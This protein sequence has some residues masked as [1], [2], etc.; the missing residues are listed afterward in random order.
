MACCTLK[1]VTM[2]CPFITV[3]VGYIIARASSLSEDSFCSSS[4]NCSGE[5]KGLSSETGIYETCMAS[6]LFNGHF[7]NSFSQCGCGDVENEWWLWKIMLVCLLES[8]PIFKTFLYFRFFK[9]DSWKW[10]LVFR[11]FWGAVN[12]EWRDGGWVWWGLNQLMVKED[13]FH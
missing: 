3:R 11:C 2:V 4:R 10:N 1:A 5:K 9:F 13:M 8:T 7:L 12:V 6:G